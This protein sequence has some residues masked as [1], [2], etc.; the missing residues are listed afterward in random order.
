MRA[1]ITKAAIGAYADALEVDG[2]AASAARLRALL[3]L[4][5]GFA[6]RPLAELIVVLEKLAPNT[7]KA[8]R[9]ARNKSE[10]IGSVLQSLEALQRLMSHTST[11]RRVR[12][13]RALC[14]VLATHESHTVDE[15]LDSVKVQRRGKIGGDPMDLHTSLASKLK[16]ALGRDTDFLP[17]FDQLK[18]MPAR[19]IALVAGSLMRGGSSGSHRNDLERILERHE[20]LASELAKRRSTSGRS[21]A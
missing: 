8:N 18:K 6:S 16:A 7:P 12:D 21:A 4:F 2:A 14:D 17:L 15:L 13:L 20:S 11:A 9:A 1:A 10:S 3:P 5:R 19:D